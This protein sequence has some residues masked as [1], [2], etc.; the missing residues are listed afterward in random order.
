MGSTPYGVDYNHGKWLLNNI[1]APYAIKDRL[2]EIAKKE[3]S[4]YLGNSL[5]CASETKIFSLPYVPINPDTLIL[6]HLKKESK[7]DFLI[8]IKGDVIKNTYNK[9]I[10]ETFLQIYNLN[11]LKIVYTRKVTGK[12]EIDED[13]NRD[14]VFSKSANGIMISSLKRILKKL[15]KK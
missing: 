8:N 4:K 14:V 13:D 7:C 3:F 5:L 1:D 11:T 6:K 9:I 15:N 2:E 10:T 12:H